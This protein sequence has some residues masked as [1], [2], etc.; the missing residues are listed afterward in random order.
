MSR[1]LRVNTGPKIIDPDPTGISISQLIGDA[2]LLVTI[3]TLNSLLEDPKLRLYRTLI[4][5]QILANIAY[6]PVKRLV[7]KERLVTKV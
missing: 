3:K 4:S 1:K 5:I 7:V 2:S 6:Q